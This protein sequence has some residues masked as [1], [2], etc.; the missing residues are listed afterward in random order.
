[1]KN[2]EEENVI[3]KPATDVRVG[4]QVVER[5]GCLL[6]VVTVERIG[7]HVHFSLKTTMQSNITAKILYTK[8]VRVFQCNEEN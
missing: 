6:E 7:R 8:Q 1:M 5:D 4:E 2:W 3:Y